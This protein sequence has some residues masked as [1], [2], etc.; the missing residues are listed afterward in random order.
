MCEERDKAKYNPSEPK[1]SGNEVRCQEL[2]DLAIVDTCLL[3][4][5]RL[6]E[7]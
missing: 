6:R 7:K 3:L 1:G 2:K 5:R 4:L